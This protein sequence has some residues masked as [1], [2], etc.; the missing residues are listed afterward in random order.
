MILKD[1]I[2]NTVVDGDVLMY[3]REFLKSKWIV[4]NDYI[5][6][7]PWTLEVFVFKYKN[8]TTKQSIEEEIGIYTEIIWNI[9][10]DPQII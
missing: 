6:P 10:K 7:V 4:L 1:K 2:W 3:E 9:Y 5:Y 8:T